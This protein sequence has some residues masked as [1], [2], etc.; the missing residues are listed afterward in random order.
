MAAKESKRFA[1]ATKKDPVNITDWLNG[2][3]SIVIIGACP[4]KPRTTFP[5]LSA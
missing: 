4:M 5:S 2:T 1:P 3:R